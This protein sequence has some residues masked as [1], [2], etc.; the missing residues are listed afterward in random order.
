MF[1]AQYQFTDNLRPELVFKNEKKL[2]WQI[3]MNL[4]QARDGLSRFKNPCYD[5]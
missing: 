1:L 5:T 4:F 2:L 3:Y